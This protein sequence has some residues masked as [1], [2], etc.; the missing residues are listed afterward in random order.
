MIGPY[1]HNIDP[2]LVDMGGVYFWWYGLGYALGFLEIHV[3]LNRARHRLGLRPAEVYTLSILFMV[4]VLVGGRFVEVTFDEWPFYREHP[5]LVPAYWLGG[6]ASHGLLLGAAT[7]TWIF[8]TACKKPFLSIADELVIP[9]AFLLGMGRIGNFIDGQIVGSV[10]DVW[11]GVKFPDVEGF[12]HP[13]V[14]YDGAKN[15][16]LIPVLLWIRRSQPAQG[17]TSAHFIFWYGFLR[18]FL[19]L[20]REY[21]THRLGFPTGQTF[22][23]VMSILGAALLV[24]ASLKRRETE[25]YRP[26]NAAPTPAGSPGRAG[27]L[28][29]KRAIF[30]SL[31]LLSLTMPSNWT[32]DI[33][34]RYGTRHPGLRHSLMYPCI[35]TAAPG[36]ER[37]STHV[38][39]GNR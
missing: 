6:M 22:N 18:I 23:I 15:L 38:I 31:L 27:S 1:V 39:A 36:M 8:S 13:V 30:T 26:C 14:L 35:Q 32:Q 11:W 24:R 7:A 19:D 16:L 25:R 37:L 2:V 29:L 33:P 17:V 10:T 12:R 20:F 4:G 28:V 5:S 21:P 9:G 34:A 3:F